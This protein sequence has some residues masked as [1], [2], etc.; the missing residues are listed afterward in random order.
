MKFRFFT[1]A[2]FTAVLAFSCI[3]CK[4]KKQNNNT[5]EDEQTALEAPAYSADSA[6][7]YVKAQTDFGPRIPNTMAHEKCARFLQEELTKYCDTV[8][9]QHFNAKAFDGTMLK[10]CN[11]IGIFNPQCEKRI[12]LASHWDSRPWANADPEEQNREKPIDGANDGASGVGVLME[13]ARQLSLKAPEIG[14]DIV[15][16]D[17]EDY[18]TD[19]ESDSWGLGA[20]YWSR[21]PH[22]SGYRAGYGILLD[23]VGAANARFRYE[24]F[25]ATYARS[26]LNNVWNIAY[27]LGYGNVFQQ[28]SAH[29]ITDDHYYVNTIAGIPMIDI[30]HQEDQTGTGFPSTWHTLEDNISNIDKNMLAT[31]GKTLLCVIYNEK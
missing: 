13:M 17:S 11:I 31:V 25:S 19:G 26:V 10:S 27:R 15:F 14:V 29:A 21:N 28:E 24:Q 20:Q 5:E 4:E 23:M 3:S 6:Y 1:I 18:G 12:V 2:C 7:Y 9:M 8:I 22:V 30:I 16:F